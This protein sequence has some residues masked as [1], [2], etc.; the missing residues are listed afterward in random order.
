MATKADWS[1]PRAPGRR[2]ARFAAGGWFISRW[3]NGAPQR[4]PQRPRRARS[5]VSVSL[6]PNTEYPPLDPAA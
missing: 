1:L 3:V 5:P 4:R 2:K 6:I